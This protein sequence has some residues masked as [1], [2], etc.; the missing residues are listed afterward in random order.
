MM[1]TLPGCSIRGD[2]MLASTDSTLQTPQGDVD[3]KPH[4]GVAPPV[5][6]A[7]WL[8]DRVGLSFCPELSHHIDLATVLAEDHRRT[9]GERA[10]ARAWLSALEALI[11]EADDA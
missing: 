6:P 9:P 7:G 2:I 10:T 3:T 5:I 1:V 8:A 4:T 11:P